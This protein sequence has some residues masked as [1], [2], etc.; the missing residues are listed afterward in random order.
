[1]LKTA[2]AG[3]RSH[4][5]RL[6][7]TVL[8][9]VL[10]VGFVTGTLIYSD[11]VREG[12]FETFARVAH[13]ADAVVFAP[14]AQE[15]SRIGELSTVDEMDVR[16]VASLALL[17]RD[18]RPVTN[19]GRVGVAVPS[20]APAAL[21]AFDLEGRTP[22]GRG[23][24]L[25]DKQTAQ[26]TGYAIGDTVTVLDAGGSR[27][28]LR[29]VGLM[30]FGVSKTM[31]GSSVVGL[32]IAEM[33]ALTGPPE[34]TEVA[35]SARPGVSADAL[36][37]S[38]RS[39]T[40]AEV[41][42]G[43]QR[44]IELAD[45]AT[46]VAGQLTLVLLLFGVISGVV[47][48]FV[49]YNTFA[50]LLVQRIRETA[51]LRCV[52]ATRRQV[53]GS[54]LTEAVIVGFAGSAI[55]LLLGIGVGHLL[56][57]AFAVLGNPVY[58]V[59]ITPRSLLI[60][61][62]IGVVATV[63]AALLPALR[64]TRIPPMAALRSLP[65]AP[66]G[67]RRWVLRAVGAVL[68][69]ALGVAVTVLGW[70]E[71][72]SESGTAII[73]AGGSIAFLGILVASPLLIGPLIAVIGAPLRPLTATPGRVA[74]ANARR[75]PGRTAVTAGALMIGVGL[76][77]LFSVVI[78]SVQA[79]ADKQIELHYPVDYIVSGL[80]HESGEAVG[81]PPALA[82]KLRSRSEFTTVIQA[83]AVPVRLAAGDQVVDGAIGAQSTTTGDEVLLN[84]GLSWSD[85]LK[86]GD[87]VIV[88]LGGKDFPLTITGTTGVALP[89]AGRADLQI[90]WE[91]L[92]RMAGPG[93]DGAVMVKAR[94]GV[95]AV[96]S[97]DILEGL[98]ADYPLIE[99]GSVADLA[100][101][102]EEQVNGLVALFGGILGLT[103]LIALFGIANTLSLSV[104]E[105]TRESAMMRAIGLTRGQLRGTLL[106]EAVLM[107][108]AAGGIG[109]AFGL[110]YGRIVVL[111]IL[112]DI[113]A[114]VALPWSWLAGLLAMAAVA[115][116]LAA[117]L[118]ARRAAGAS[119]VSAMAD[120]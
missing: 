113:G 114:T 73:V 108:V 82:D 110:L 28:E 80:R 24:A 119:I 16:A 75:N 31:S 54:T 85:G 72:G 57:M 40:G 50:I 32:P 29:L 102:L 20:D 65:L 66:A 98:R 27:V 39:V 10:G 4:A 49:I 17:D 79:S 87:T 84:T 112:S 101:Q 22:A 43:D 1:M 52:G 35:L 95:S 97:R 59:V 70:R 48:V 88:S 89:G 12:Y 42:T 45:Q 86:P 19:F 116:L 71:E 81:I 103:V 92:T 67:R 74:V 37:G 47:A 69:G 111:K 60:G 18:G 77:A 15:V 115:S 7:G 23:E 90:S 120:T 96:A 13:N 62:A 91:A 56:P 11:T 78:A 68:I 61:L 118:P 106:L 76:M 33:Q 21:R 38:L 64:A 94:D 105:R 46:A 8:A 55:G 14:S 41:V 117:V 109:V 34:I 99:I 107:G 6:V 93:D 26:H 9:A 83:R 63:A 2:F 30:D 44:R 53:L 51:L 25:L 36:V 100:D 104:F 3:V 58:D 5:R